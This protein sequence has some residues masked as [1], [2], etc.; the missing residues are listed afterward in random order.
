MVIPLSPGSGTL[1][2]SKRKLEAKRGSLMQS[3]YANEE[4][5]QSLADE[6]TGLKFPIEKPFNWA[7]S[8][9]LKLLLRYV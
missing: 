2:I 7:Q 1:A 6:Y 3:V 8:F 4:G 5:G 9:L